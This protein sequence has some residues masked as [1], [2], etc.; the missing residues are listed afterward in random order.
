M[1]KNINIESTLSSSKRTRMKKAIGGSL[2][3]I[4][5]GGDY[6]IRGMRKSNI[7]SGNQ[8]NLSYEKEGREQTQTMSI[9][10][11][12]EERDIVGEYARMF[13]NM[14]EYSK[15]PFLEE[16]DL[17]LRNRGLLYLDAPDNFNLKSID[18]YGVSIDGYIDHDEDFPD[19]GTVINI[20]LDLLL[21]FNSFSGKFISCYLSD[22]G[23][24][25]LE[26]HSDIIAFNSFINNSQEFWDDYESLKYKYSI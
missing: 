1:K 11:K 18:V 9:F 12:I 6:G 25:R 20:N 8:V 19:E 7:F 5:I 17:L 23:D 13:V 15:S 4:I 22:S 2:K 3:N 21:K 26:L 16:K 14:Y 10:S 24:V